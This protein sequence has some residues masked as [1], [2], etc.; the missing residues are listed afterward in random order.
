MELREAE[1]LAR[2]LM[3]EWGL[4]DWTFKFDRARTRFG[5][6]QRM[7]GGHPMKDGAPG[8]ITLSGPVTQM[9]DREQVEDT[10]RHEIAH[11]LAPLTAGH[12]YEWRRW[13]YK[14]GAKPTRCGGGRTPPRRYELVCAADSNPCRMPRHNRTRKQYRCRRHR[15]EMVLMKRE[16][17]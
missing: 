10:I 7:R 6:V 5:S 9:N 15:T 1:R 12:G 13:C 3:D 14:V 4:S 16:A 17:S 2:D 8:W 11:A